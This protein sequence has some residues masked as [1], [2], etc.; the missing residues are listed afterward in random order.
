MPK[1]GLGLNGVNIILRDFEITESFANNVCTYV[2]RED[3]FT[4]SNARKRARGWRT[5]IS[6]EDV[7]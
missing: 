7:L 6:R 2:R 4:G 1:T 3:N 5:R